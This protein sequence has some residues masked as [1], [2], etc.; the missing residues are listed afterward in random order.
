[1]NKI[2]YALKKIGMTLLFFSIIIAV[3]YLIWFIFGT[4][5]EGNER[6]TIVSPEDVFKSFYMFFI[7]NENNFWIHMLETFKR[8]FIGYAISIGIAIILALLMRSLTIF[9]NELKAILSGL[10]SLPNI[11]W[12]PFAIILCGLD[13]SAV[14]F[15]IIMGSAPAI[16]LAIRSSFMNI[17]PLYTR[18]G[19]T[20][21]CNGIGMMLRI[22][23]PAALPSLIVALKQGWAF[24]WR[25]LMAGEMNCLFAIPPRGLGHL[26]DTMRSASSLANLFCITVVIIIIGMLFEKVFFS[27]AEDK[28]LAKRGLSR[29]IK[30]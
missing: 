19:K 9:S 6:L 14:Y 12:V 13:E 24:S 25:A 7:K 16:A 23:I 30:E 20:L 5:A 2:L 29:E 8:L 17:D 15:I 21:G 10:Q 18:V 28:I 22:Y 11:C 27:I 1:M 3:W 4:D 26:L